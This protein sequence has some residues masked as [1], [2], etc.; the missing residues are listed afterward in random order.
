MNGYEIGRDI[1][2]LRSRVELLEGNRSGNLKP[3]KCGK[4][5][6]ARPKMELGVDQTVKPML[7]RATKRSEVPPFVHG[8]LGIRP[9]V[10]LDSAESQ[11]WTC[12]PEPLI[13]NVNW[14]SGGSDEL[15]R[16]QGQLF[17][18]FRATDPNTGV[19]TC[20]A[21][22]SAQLVASGVG[23]AHEPYA[24]LLYFNVTLRNAAGGDLTYL[25]PPIQYM[26]DCHDNYPFGRIWQFDP[27]LYDLVA[28]AHW[29]VDGQERIDRC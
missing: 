26:V 20:S 3:C 12:T 9:G 29:Y 24:G 15:Y 13:F 28:G 17:T 21:S 11:T 23:K 2:E 10:K 5:T 14:D 27:G 22:Y 7:W 19:T 16:L 6:I 18:I 1:Q 4:G 8:L 25:V